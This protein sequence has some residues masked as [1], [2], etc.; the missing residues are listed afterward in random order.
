[1]IRRRL[2][3]ALSCCLLFATA[4]EAKWSDAL[5]QELPARKQAEAR[6]NADALVATLLAQIRRKAAGGDCPMMLTGTDADRFGVSCM[7]VRTQHGLHSAHALHARDDQPVKTK[8]ATQPGWPAMRDIVLDAFERAVQPLASRHFLSGHYQPIANPIWLQPDHWATDKQGA[9]FLLQDGRTL[10][11]VEYAHALDHGNKTYSSLVSASL[12]DVRS[13]PPPVWR[14]AAT[15]DR[16]VGN[17]Q[18][19]EGREV[20]RAAVANSEALQGLRNHARRHQLIRP[21]NAAPLDPNTGSALT[22]AARQLGLTLAELRWQAMDQHA[23]DIPRVLGKVAQTQ[24]AINAEERRRYLAAVAAINAQHGNANSSDNH[25]FSDAMNSALSA[26]RREQQF[27]QI[28]R[29]VAETGP[30]TRSTAPAARSDKQRAGTTTPN[31]GNAAPG[32]SQAAGADACDLQGPVPSPAPLIQ[33]CAQR[34]LQAGRFCMWT[35]DMFV[36][37]GTGCRS[38]EQTEAGVREA[39]QARAG[40]PLPTDMTYANSNIRGARLCPDKQVALPALPS[41]RCEQPVSVT[42]GQSFGPGVAC[43][44]DFSYDCQPREPGRSSGSSG[45]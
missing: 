10:L 6:Q 18:S 40:K 28:R 9:E 30:A 37:V 38:P 33:S 42:M 26:L 19:V 15:S 45:R 29:R 13:L 4:A 23:L 1:M 22:P 24:D 25:V 12:I 43:V 16:F 20:S 14:V 35:A 7:Q 31:A 44:A 36:R 27:A 5:Y 17:G 32:G 41:I 3:T 34:P 8:Y 39:L 2:C 11:V 21:L